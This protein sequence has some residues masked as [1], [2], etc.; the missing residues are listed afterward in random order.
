MQA[1]H[2][3]LQ[4]RNLL[5]EP[6]RFGLARLRWFLPIS[7][8]ELPQITDYAFLDLR[9]APFH[10]RPGKVLVPI[11]HCLELAAI[12]YHAGPNKQFSLSAK[13]NEPCANLA[14]GPAIVLAEVGNRLVI[15]D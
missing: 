3:L 13:H 7:T 11:V 10:L 4:L 2:L 9:Q 14:D 15:R 8:V 5:L 6:G 1:L 12:N